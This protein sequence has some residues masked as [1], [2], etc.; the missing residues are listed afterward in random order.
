M[1]VLPFG[2]VPQTRHVRRSNMTFIGV[3]NDRVP[4]RAI[5][6]SAL[7]IRFISSAYAWSRV[8]VKYKDPMVVPSSS[9]SGAVTTRN[10]LPPI[11]ATPSKLSA[12]LDAMSVTARR[13]LVVSKGS[14][15]LSA[16]LMLCEETVNSTVYPS[17]GALDPRVFL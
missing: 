14:L 16:W 3:V 6:I 7:E 10:V 1:H 9:R 17:P 13:S 5:V 2:E 15:G 4:G 8:A 11:C 12:S